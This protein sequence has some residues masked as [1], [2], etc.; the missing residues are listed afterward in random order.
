MN[1]ENTRIVQYVSRKRDKTTGKYVGP[2]VGV[3]VAQIRPDNPNQVGIG[4]ALAKK[5]DEFDKELGL[6]VA[7]NRAAL[8]SG[9]GVDGKRNESKVPASL[10]EE[11]L[12][13]Y[14]RAKRYFRDKE[15]ILPPVNS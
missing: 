9:C 14:D 5:G 1:S 8:L 6:T 13:V 3:V 7:T 10:S 11:V 4:W 15:V 2:R 12:N